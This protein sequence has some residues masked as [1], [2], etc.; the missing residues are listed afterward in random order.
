MR[1]SSASYLRLHVHQTMDSKIDHPCHRVSLLRGSKE[2]SSLKPPKDVEDE[3]ADKCGK[4]F[5]ESSQHISSRSRSLVNPSR[6]LI[7][8]N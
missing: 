2:H 4:A 1:D 8:E 3:F 7:I 6:A 5:T